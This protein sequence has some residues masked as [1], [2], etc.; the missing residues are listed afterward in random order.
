[1]DEKQK[2]LE[3]LTS[4]VTSYLEKL[5]YSDSRISQYHSAFYWR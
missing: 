2:A 5:S 3:T 4:E 1:M